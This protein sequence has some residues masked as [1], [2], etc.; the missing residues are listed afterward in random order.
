MMNNGELVT[1]QKIKMAI[2]THVSCDTLR[3]TL[4]EMG[5]KFKKKGNDLYVH[6]RQDVVEWRIR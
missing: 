3:H 6:E 1:V 4:K 2:D 5:Y